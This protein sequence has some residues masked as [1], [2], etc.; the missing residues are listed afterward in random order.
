M[1]DLYM[2]GLVDITT[3]DQPTLERLYNEGEPFV[4]KID[5]VGDNALLE[6]PIYK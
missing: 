6:E 5:G 3:L 4:I 1:V 2:L